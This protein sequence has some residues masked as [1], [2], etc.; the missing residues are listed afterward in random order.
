MVAKRMAVIVVLLCFVCVS[1]AQDKRVYFGLRLGGSVGISADKQP[2]DPYDYE[3]E[4]DNIWV[5]KSGGGSFDIAPFISLQLADV[6]ALQ[7]ELLFTKY[8]YGGEKAKRD[9]IDGYDYDND[10]VY[11]Y[12]NIT[13]KGD[14]EVLERPAIVIPVLAQFTFAERKVK[15]FAGPHFSINTGRYRYIY[16]SKEDGK[17]I[18]ILGKKDQDE[19][20]K[21]SKIPPVGLTAGIS[22]GF[23][24]G[25]GNLFFDIRYLTDFG[26]AKETRTESYYDGY[27]PIY[28]KIE[29]DYVH[30]AKLA[31]SMGYEF[32]A[33]SR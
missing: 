31:F 16:K 10:G 30:R 26:N 19:A 12:V 8:G 4:E 7:T 29:R 1:F 21:N 32:G 13:T 5:W 3:D 15:I 25:P 24:A 18:Y 23:N 9:Y 33:G 28:I 20:D 22:F 2:K 11:D 14:Y 27:M 17:E 6:F